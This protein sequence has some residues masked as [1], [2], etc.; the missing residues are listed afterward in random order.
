MP[1]HDPA[2]Y[3]PVMNNQPAAASGQPADTRKVALE[4]RIAHQAHTLWERYGRPTD[5][6]V[7]IWLE[8]ERQ[9]LGDEG[10]VS[11]QPFGAVSAPAL[12]SARTLP[13]PPFGT[14]D[15]GIIATRKSAPAAERGR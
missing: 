13:H 2:T 9:V 11:Q 15:G 1:A 4:A 14:P 3:A 6:D 5:R 10:R 12:E 8:A 7:S